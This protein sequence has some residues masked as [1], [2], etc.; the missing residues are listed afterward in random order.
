V[1]EI[2]YQFPDMP[3]CFGRQITNVGISGDAL[4]V[5]P[6]IPSGLPL[7]EAEVQ[8]MQ[9]ASGTPSVRAFLILF[10]YGDMELSGQL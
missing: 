5:L 9:L 6:G 10:S 8:L 3:Y 1:F 4:V 7:K 2:L